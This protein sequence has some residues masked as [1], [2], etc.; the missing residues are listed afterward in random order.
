MKANGELQAIKIITSQ[1]RQIAAQRIII[2]ILDLFS[3]H[4]WYRRL[5][6]VKM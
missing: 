5:I 4:W 6:L 3:I 2:W 1:L